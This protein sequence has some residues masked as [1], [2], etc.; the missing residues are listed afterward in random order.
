L[1]LYLCRA[2]SPLKK[3]GLYAA[4]G[5]YRIERLRRVLLILQQLPGQTPDFL[6]LEHLV[7]QL[8][9]I[10]KAL[11]SDYAAPKAQVERPLPK[12]AQMKT[13]DLPAPAAS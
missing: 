6:A 9:L 10:A 4:G 2:E 7:E 12:K 1:V 13:G 3:I 8:V 11:D 5:W